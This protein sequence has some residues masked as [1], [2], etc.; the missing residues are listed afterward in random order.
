M[1]SQTYAFLSAEEHLRGSGY[2]EDLSLGPRKL[3]LG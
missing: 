3:R 1:L 2:Y